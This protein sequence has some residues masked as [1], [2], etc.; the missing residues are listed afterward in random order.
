MRDG[1]PYVSRSVHETLD[2]ARKSLDSLNY[3]FQG[4][5]HQII[6]YT[7]EDSHE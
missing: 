7:S 1:N 4:Y 3:W 6:K 5:D 2:E